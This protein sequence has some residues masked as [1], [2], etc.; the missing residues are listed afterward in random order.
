MSD[1]VETCRNTVTRKY[2]PIF[3]LLTWVTM[4][5]PWRLVLVA[6]ENDPHQR[7]DPGSKK[8]DVHYVATPQHIVD[9]MLRIADVKESDLVYDLGCGDGRYVVSA[10]KTYGCRARGYDID[11][12]RVRESRA[13]VKK[14]GVEHLVTIEQK[15][16]FE[17]DLSEAD[18]VTLFLLPRLNVR[19]IP[20]LEKLK[21]GARV[22]S[23]A[24]DMKG[25]EPDVEISVFHPRHGRHA[26]YLWTAP[27]KKVIP[28][29]MEP[30]VRGP[31]GLR[32]GFLNK[33]WNHVSQSVPF[34]LAIV[35][36]VLAVPVW[37]LRKRWGIVKINVTIERSKRL[38]EKNSN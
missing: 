3:L 27:L 11:P 15:D 7:N 16:I 35:V 1:V 22:I 33:L 26:I 28:S 24:F 13:N 32:Y 31:H 20:Q 12:N 19:L 5:A 30:D 4:L 17:L 2:R 29:A 23:Y 38:D 9:L 34:L 6:Q 18:V 36:A 8:P 10:A 37:L 14:A 25:V 21:P